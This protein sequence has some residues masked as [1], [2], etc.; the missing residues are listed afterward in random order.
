MAQQR[1]PLLGIAG[2]G[3]VWE[4]VHQAFELEAIRPVDIRQARVEREFQL[5]QPLGQVQNRFERDENIGQQNDEQRQADGVQGWRRQMRH[6][7][8]HQRVHKA[9]HQ[10]GQRAKNHKSLQA[11][12]AM[13]V[14]KAVAVIP[15]ARVQKRFHQPGGYVFQR[16]RERG[17]GKKQRGGV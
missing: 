3:E 1:L 2:E 15:P 8:F 7:A 17:A 6:Q 13:K 4:G 11:Y 5:P 12:P 9:Q 14:Q 10:H 16:C